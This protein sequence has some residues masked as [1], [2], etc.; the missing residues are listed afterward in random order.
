MA[1]ERKINEGNLYSWVR[2]ERRRTEA[3]KGT[4]N[5]R[6][7]GAER[8]DLVKLRKQVQEQ[9]REL[10]VWGQAASYCGA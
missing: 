6:L 4:D 10:E 7:S 2:D 3:A 5:E 8:A 9:E 1:D